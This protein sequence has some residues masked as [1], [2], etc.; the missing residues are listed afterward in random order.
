MKVLITG[1]AGFI[2]SHTADLLLEKGYEVRILD[3][4]EPPVHPQKRKPDYLCADVEFILGDV[5][6]KSDV[7]KALQGVDSVFHLAAYQGYLTDFSKFAF[8]N[9]AST[10]LIYEVILEKGLPVGK[11]VLA[12]SQAVYGEGRYHCARDGTQYPPPR[13][14][15]QLERGDWGL[16]CPV[17]QQPMEPLPTDESRVSPHNQYAVSKY[18][19]ELYALT[20]GRRFGIPTVVLRYSITQGPR[21]SFYNA[22]S[23]ILRISATRLLQNLRPIL[24]EDGKQLR[25]YVYVKDVAAANILAMESKA[26][27]YQI[28]N[29]G[30]SEVIS[31]SEYVKVLSKVVGREVIPEIPGEF[32]FG[33]VRHIISDISKIRELGWQPRTSLEQIMSEYFEWATEQ[34]EVRDFYTEASQVMKQMG[35]IRATR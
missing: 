10:A 34:P 7:Q 28:Y 11:V 26:A 20:L 13:P 30:G 17:C 23:G 2:G 32:R 15:E 12:S 33:D 35:V 18:C 1:G 19:Q 22:Y 27:T 14:L 5:R 31:V 3:S 29:V 21:Q 16:E 25:D 4:L 24:Y 9:D 6:N 8:T